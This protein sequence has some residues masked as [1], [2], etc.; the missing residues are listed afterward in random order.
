M[1]DSADSTLLYSTLLTDCSPPGSF[2]HRIL[3]ARILEWVIIPFS[4][5]WSRPRIEPG[6]GKPLPPD[7]RG[8]LQLLDGYGSSSSPFLL[9]NTIV[10][11]ASILLVD[12]ESPGSTPGF[13][14]FTPVKIEEHLITVGLEEVQACHV[15]SMTRMVAILTI[16]GEGCRS[17]RSIL[18]LLWHDLHGSVGNT[19]L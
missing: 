17:P 5:E 8:T 11:V 10:W 4:R 1:C 6:S 7:I 16:T 2:V 14:W 3:Q 15:V 13:F 18:D 9:T 19:S 12:S